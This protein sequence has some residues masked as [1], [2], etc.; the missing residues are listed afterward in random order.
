MVSAMTFFDLVDTLGRRGTAKL[1]SEVCAA[2]GWRTIG[3][4]AIRR[5]YDG[6]VRPSEKIL[7]ACEAL[8][9]KEL[10]RKRFDRRKTIVEWDRRRSAWKAGAGSAR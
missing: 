8:P 2:R 4:A 7:D 5:A 1:L 6:R 3:E 10:G 9:A